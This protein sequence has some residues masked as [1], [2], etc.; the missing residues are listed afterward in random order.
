MQL[1]AQ[2]PNICCAEVSTVVQNDFLATTR[3]RLA[4]ALPRDFFPKQETEK[5]NGSYSEWD[6]DPDP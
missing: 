6:T 4:S 3:L 5:T 2:S 1:I